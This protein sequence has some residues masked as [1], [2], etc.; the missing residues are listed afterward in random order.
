MT[1]RCVPA[2][3]GPVPAANIG[4]FSFELATP[5]DNEDLLRFAAQADMPGAI[6]FSLDRSPDYLAALRVE[7]RDN[8]V[9]ICRETKTGKLVATGQRS[10]KNVFVNGR[11]TPVGYLSGLRVGPRVRNGMFLS[12]GY[13]QLHALHVRRPASFYLTTIMEENLPARKVLERLALPAYH[14]L[15]QFCC[16][17]ASLAGKAGVSSEFRLRPANAADAIAVVGFLNREGRTK[18]FFPQY[19]VEDFGRSDGLLPCLNW[20][21]V[22]LAF[23]GTE[24][25]GV[26]AAWD[27]QAFRRWHVTGYSP[28]LRWSRHLLNLGAKLRRLPLLPSPGSP[29]NY[30]NLALICIR[31]NN[32]KIFGALLD[33][34]LRAHQGRY[35]FFLAG[36]HKRDPLLPE[37]LSRAH[38]PLTSRLYRVDWEKESGAVQSVEDLRVPY[39]E[40]GSL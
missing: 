18:Q 10:I 4:R 40:L 32:R 22:F 30:F 19:R 36:L 3:S 13:E 9:L 8:E 38:V 27:Q 26:L 11:S 24:L 33:M 25:A 39:L 17:A 21:D 37:L 31:D 6:Q 1:T 15:G 28:W 2:S 34:V 29:P 5:A 14:D 7:G 20:N 23:H 16:M 12:K 35:A